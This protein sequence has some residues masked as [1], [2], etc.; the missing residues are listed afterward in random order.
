MNTKRPG[1]ISSDFVFHVRP[2]SIQF[3]A[4]VSMKLKQVLFTFIMSCAPAR[5]A[6]SPTVAIPPA[7]QLQVKCQQGL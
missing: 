5:K 6:E 7:H 4:A 1:P 3:L 2:L